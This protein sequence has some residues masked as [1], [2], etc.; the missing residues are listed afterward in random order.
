MDDKYPDDECKYPDTEWVDEWENDDWEENPNDDWGDLVEDIGELH[1]SGKSRVNINK[2]NYSDEDIK[3]EIEDQYNIIKIDVNILYEIFKIFTNV[4]LENIKINIIFE[5][6]LEIR[7][8]TVNTDIRNEDLTP[9]DILILC[10]INKIIRNMKLDLREKFI[11][12]IMHQIVTY[13]SNDIYKRCYICDNMGVVDKNIFNNKVILNLCGS[14][15]CITNSFISKNFIV[16]EEI[17]TNWDRFEVMLYLFMYSCYVNRIP[18]ILPDDT[19]LN[20]VIKILSTLPPIEMIKNAENLKLMFSEELYSILSWLIFTYLNKVEFIK[21]TKN[22]IEFKINESSEIKDMVFKD[23]NKSDIFNMHHGSNDFNYFNIIMNG[24]QSFSKSKYQ[25]NGAAY[26]SGVYFGTIQTAK[27]YNVNRGGGIIRRKNKNQ[28]PPPPKL[29]SKSKDCDYHKIVGDLINGCK[30]HN[31]N[32]ILNCDI[33]YEDKKWVKNH[34]CTVIPK[35]EN[36][37]IKKLI[38][39]DR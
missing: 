33:Y 34:F 30:Y 21:R 18:C 9:T 20:N 37:I 10:K 24:L 7:R 12:K 39:Y 23:A 4:S 26:G 17:M 36:I 11:L 3:I 35:S 14:L 13:I 29:P 38:V 2:G 8:I 16:E 32:K 22:F 5:N 15:T 27:S 1:I 6:D 31:I 25:T 28:K 19:D